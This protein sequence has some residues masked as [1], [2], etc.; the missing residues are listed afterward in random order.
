MVKIAAIVGSTSPRKALNM[1]AVKIALSALDVNIA[2]TTSSKD[3]GTAGKAAMTLPNRTC[4]SVMITK[5]VHLDAP[6]LRAA[7]SG[8]MSWLLS[9][10]PMEITTSLSAR[11]LCAHSRPLSEQGDLRFAED[12]NRLDRDR[13]HYGGDQHL[14]GDLYKARQAGCQ[15]RRD[16]PAL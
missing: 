2:T 11:M 5:A 13:D 9:A 1:F 16:L 15:S 14:I 3:V 4:G 7:V 10:V 8:L 12:I 6:E